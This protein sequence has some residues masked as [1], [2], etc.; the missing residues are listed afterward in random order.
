ML[1][2]ASIALWIGAIGSA[3]LAVVAVEHR[4]GRPAA[5]RGARGRHPARGGPV[6]GCARGDSA[7]GAVHRARVRHPRRPARRARSSRRSCSSSLARAAVPDPYSSLPTRC[8]SMCRN[9]CALGLALLGGPARRGRAR[10][11]ACGSRRRRAPSRHGRRC[12][13]PPLPHRHARAAAAPPRLRRH[14]L[15]ARRRARVPHGA[16]RRARAPCPRRT[17]ART[18]CTTNSPASRPSPATSWRPASSPQRPPSEPREQ[19]RRHPRTER[20]R[21][22]GDPRAAPARAQFDRRRRPRG[23]SPRSPAARRRSCPEAAH[24]PCSRSRSTS[25]GSIASSSW[26]AL[27]PRRGPAATPTTSTP[28]T[29]PPIDIALSVETV[30]A[31]GPRGR[32]RVRLHAGAPAPERRVRGARPG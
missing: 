14:R 7:A 26:M 28:T 10:S 24:C 9:C 3:L 18:S 31:A 16:R 6:V 17:S 13:D 12:D 22:P 11:T 5:I 15:G 23:R 21:A 4:R 27:R 1:S 2:S 8:R 29:R 20:Q 30:R 32:R 19:R 25:T